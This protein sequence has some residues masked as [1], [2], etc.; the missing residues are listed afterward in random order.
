MLSIQMEEL[1]QLDQ[2]EPA[3]VEESTVEG[4]ALE[5][6]FGKYF[7]EYR[8]LN[9]LLFGLFFLIV[10]TVALWIFKLVIPPG[11]EPDSDFMDGGKQ[12]ASPKKQEQKVRLMQRQKSAKPTQTLPKIKRHSLTF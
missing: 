12:V 1:T 9:S 3:P 10:M 6:S 8:L 4:P 11:G 5:S 7:R 2:V